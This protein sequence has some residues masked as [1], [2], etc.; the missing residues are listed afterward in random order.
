MAMAVT[1]Q[2]K[3][4]CTAISASK[5]ASTMRDVPPARKHRFVLSNDDH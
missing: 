4:V 2:R 3:T 1:Q 5:E